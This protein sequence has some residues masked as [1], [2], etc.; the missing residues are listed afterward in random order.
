MVAA[1][2]SSYRI[3]HLHCLHQGPAIILSMSGP[4]NNGFFSNQ[5]S[6]IIP[7]PKGSDA[8]IYT[9]T[10]EGLTGCVSTGSVQID[11][12]P[13]GAFRP[14][15]ESRAPFARVTPSDFQRIGWEHRC[16]NGHTFKQDWSIT[17]VYHSSSYNPIC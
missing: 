13:N 2:C 16:M 1:I 3:L 5:S 4:P 10:I 15:L 7:D 9:L 6:P 17:P 12:D 14:E 8:G 11:I